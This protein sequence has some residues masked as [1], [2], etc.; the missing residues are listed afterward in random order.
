VQA[1]HAMY[2]ILFLYYHAIELYLKAFLRG[3]GHSAKE[4]SGRKYGHDIKNLSDRAAELGLFYMDED[5]EVFSLIVSTDAVIRSR[6]I[7]TGFFTWPSPDMLFRSCISLREGVSK[8]LIAKG[9]PIRLTV[10]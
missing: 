10:A 4:L 2:P 8:N 5:R 1:T 7:K 6:Y 9:K 3:N